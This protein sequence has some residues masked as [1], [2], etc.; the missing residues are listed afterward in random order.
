M[1]LF[2]KLFSN[3]NTKSVQEFVLGEKFPLE[4]YNSLGDHANIALQESSFDIVISLTGLSDAEIEA[5][6]DDEFD[7]YVAATDMVPFIV[8][9]F[10]STFKVDLT[11]NIL[12]MKEEFM[13]SWFK[14]PNETVRLFLLEGGDGTLKCIRTFRFEHM[15]DIKYVCRKQLNATKM[16][17][18]NHIKSIYNQVNIEGLMM[19]AQVKFVVPAALSL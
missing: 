17:I 9:K 10:G 13:D 7:V 4:G 12:K 19:A 14:S 5:I 16:E 8:L 11:L 6:G 1:G 15:K 2:S 18:D 3:K